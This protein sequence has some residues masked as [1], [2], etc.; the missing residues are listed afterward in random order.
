MTIAIGVM[1]VATLAAAAFDVRTRRIPNFVTFGAAAAALAVHAPEG[2]TPELTSVAA[3]LVAFVLG[4]LAF[5]AGWFGGGD[6]KLIAACCG[7]V[8]LPGA[9]WLVLDILVAGGALALVA[10][11]FSGRLVA[12]VRSAAVVA[13][14]GAPTER[15]ALPY[16]IAIA[17]GSLVFAVSTIVRPM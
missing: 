6:V 14:N 16:G 5:S 9:I 1:L 17:G 7:L 13:L 10:A 11:A 2:I 3:M 12:L 4:S 15:T 8:S